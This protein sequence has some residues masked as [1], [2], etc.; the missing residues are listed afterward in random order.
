MQNKFKIFTIFLGCLLF[1]LLPL[2]APN[3]EP[4]MAS[5]MPLG[6]KHNALFSF[7]FGFLSI[8]LYD[9]LTN[10][11]YWTWTV[12]IAYG[13]VGAASSLYFKNK[14]KASIWNFAKF[15]FFATILFDLATGVLLAPLFGQSIYT[16]FM[17]QIPFTLLHLAGNLGFALT[18]SPL[19]GKWLASEKFFSLEHKFLTTLPLSWKGNK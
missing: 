8:F 18:L 14:E 9:L 6:K 4:L 15:T 10:Y 1:R 11:G 13:L 16:A 3:V 7:A 2:R 12:G 17:L 5:L 19:I